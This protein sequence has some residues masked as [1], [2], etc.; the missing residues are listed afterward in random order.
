MKTLKHANKR[1]DRLANFATDFYVENH[2]FHY[3]TQE[4]SNNCVVCGTAVG[5][6]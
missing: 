1:L 5:I 2:H 3:F 6:L 4:N